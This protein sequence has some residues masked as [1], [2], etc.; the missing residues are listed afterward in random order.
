[1]FWSGGPTRARELAVM[2]V[3]GKPQR[4]FKL[5]TVHSARNFASSPLSGEPQADCELVKRSTMRRRRREGGRTE[6]RKKGGKEGG[7]Q[8]GRREEPRSK[9]I[10]NLGT[11]PGSL[12]GGE[13]FE[14]TN[15]HQPFFVAV[16]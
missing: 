4:A 15:I 8:E 2:F 5:A 11:S 13:I 16:K 6:G 9:M 12:A 3:S 10:S 14:A 1:V 7:K